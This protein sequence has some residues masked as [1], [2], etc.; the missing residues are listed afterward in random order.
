MYPVVSPSFGEAAASI[1]HPCDRNRSTLLFSRIEKQIYVPA[2][3]ITVPPP[4]A[5]AASIALLIAGESTVFPS[6]V[7]P[8]VRT[9]KKI[10]ER[11]VASTFFRAA[12]TGTAEKAEA[13]RPILLSLKR[14]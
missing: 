1:V 9:S 10:G 5:A 14:S 3:K 4:A 2:G 7:A 8:Y 13:A 11:A 6:P 12:S